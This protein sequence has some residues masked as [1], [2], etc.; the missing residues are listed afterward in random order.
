V[1]LPRLPRRRL[2]VLTAAIV[3]LTGAPALYLILGRTPVQ[4]PIA[5]S[6]FM[7]HVEAGRV[8]QVNFE[9]RHLVVGLQ[10]GSRVTTV[11]PAEFLNGNAAFLRASPAGTSGSSSCRRR[12]P[13]R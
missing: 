7:Q 13:T 5:F 9:E 11:A 3:A 1:A 10:D 6:E 4:A 2:L 8:A 12:I